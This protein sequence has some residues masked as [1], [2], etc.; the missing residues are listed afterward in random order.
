MLV[1]NDACVID[2]P[3]KFGAT[4]TGAQTLLY[5]LHSGSPNRAIKYLQPVELVFSASNRTQIDD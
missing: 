3:K 1:N 4:G 5:A 2:A